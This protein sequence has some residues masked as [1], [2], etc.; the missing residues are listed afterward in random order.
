VLFRT[1]HMIADHI[2][3]SRKFYETA[4]ADPEPES[5]IA[6]AVE[7]YTL[8]FR[9]LSREYLA[10]SPFFKEYMAA[11]KYRPTSIFDDLKSAK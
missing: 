8:T 7:L 11:M 9:R 2:E 6:E 1:A 3:E 5:N 10:E 4:T